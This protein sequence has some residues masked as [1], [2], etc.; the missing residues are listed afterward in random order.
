VDPDPEDVLSFVGI[1]DTGLTGVLTDNDDGTYTYDPNGLFEGLAV[2]PAGTDVFSYQITDSQ[3]KLSTGTVE[4]TVTG[5]NDS[6][7]AV[8]DDVQTDESTPLSLADLTGN[9]TDPDADDVLTIIAVDDAGTLGT[10]R[11]GT[12]WN[13]HLRSQRRLRRPCPGCVRHRYLHLHR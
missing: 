2:G 8:D 7:T 1:D 9:D 12:G 5:V 3:G 10:G 6:V 13:G 4:I 11:T